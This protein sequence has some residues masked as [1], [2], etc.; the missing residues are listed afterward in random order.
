MVS[1]L[2]TV[3]ADN[4]PGAL[5]RV[6]TLLGKEKINIRAVNITS[7]GESGY[8]HLV[9]DD[10]EGAHAALKKAGIDNH[11]KKVIAVLIEDKPGSL[12][13]LIDLLHK[14]GINV[15][16]ACGFVLESYKKAVFVVDVDK[17]DEALKL[18][19]KEKFKT[20]DAESLNAVEPFHYMKY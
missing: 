6:T 13:V 7:F 15:E 4:K 10:P 3:P 11:L 14:N 20:L 1:F 5:S 17:L 9:V 19:E 8:F 16:N 2:L 12:N 18:L